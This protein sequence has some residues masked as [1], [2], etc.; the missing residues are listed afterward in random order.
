MPERQYVNGRFRER[1]PI[2]RELNRDDV[3]VPLRAAIFDIGPGFNNALLRDETYEGILARNRFLV[4]PISDCP[5][6]VWG[7]SYFSVDESPY[8]ARHF[9]TE[10]RFGLTLVV[11]ASER[12]FVFD[13]DGVPFD[14]GK[15]GLRSRERAHRV[16]RRGRF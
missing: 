5:S 7:W 11:R 16:P 14:P 1:L 9:I 4:S 13:T 6:E 15:V 3:L 2:N 8:L 12:L 10:W